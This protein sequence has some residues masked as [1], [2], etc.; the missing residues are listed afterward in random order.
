MNPREEQYEAAISEARS[1]V[2]AAGAE[3]SALAFTDEEPAPES[4]QQ[5]RFRY[6]MERDF[7]RK[8]PHGN[9][10]QVL[11]IFGCEPNRAHCHA[12]AHRRAAELG[13]G[14]KLPT[15]TC[16]FC[17]VHFQR[18]AV[19]TVAFNVAAVVVCASICVGCLSVRPTVNT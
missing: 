11:T 8:C 14:A 12:C 18:A 6:A 19:G 1:I 15:V 13:R 16:D 9:N 5:W 10:S 7:L 2:Q 17:G 3:W 4:V